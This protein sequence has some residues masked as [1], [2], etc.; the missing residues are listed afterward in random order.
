MLVLFRGDEGISG[1]L[2]FNLPQV[3]I[4][5]YCVLPCFKVQM[6]FTGGGGE[7]AEREGVWRGEHHLQDL[8]VKK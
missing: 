3:P 2:Q 4:N 6:K 8:N 5:I 1:G 7:A